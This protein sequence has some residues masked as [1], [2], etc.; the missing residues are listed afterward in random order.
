MCECCGGDCKLSDEF[1]RT[2]ANQNI[3]H[4]YVQMVG[5]ISEDLLGHDDYVS[6]DPIRSYP[7]RII[8]GDSSVELPKPITFKC[9]DGFETYAID[10]STIGVRPKWVSVQEKEPPKDLELLGY[11]NGK[12]FIFSYRM[13]SFHE[14]S[15][16][17]IAYEVSPTHWMHLPKTTH[18]KHL[19]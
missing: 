2:G 17:E 10:E 16:S 13:G 4:E 11:E 5:G 15:Q 19:T 14:C 1:K 3:D 18:K 9:E 12:K 7:A 6:P 8:F